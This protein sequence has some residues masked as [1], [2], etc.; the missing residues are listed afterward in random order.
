MICHKI[1]EN[2]KYIFV[3][4]PVIQVPPYNIVSVITQLRFVSFSTS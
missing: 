1:K 3:I 4:I 2:Y